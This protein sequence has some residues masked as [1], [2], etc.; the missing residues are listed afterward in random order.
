MTTVPRRVIDRPTARLAAGLLVLLTLIGLISAA[1]AAAD[2]GPS[3]AVTWGVAPI[4]TG[5]AHF[6]GAAGPGDTVRDAISIVNRSTTP[7]TLRVYASDAFTTATGGLDL[8]PAAQKPVDLGSW[9]TLDQDS[10]TLTSQ[11]TVVVPF[12]VRVP[13]DATPGDHT[14]GIVT[15]LVT[16][17]SG[18]AVQLDRRLGARYYL[19]VNGSLAPALAVSNVHVSYAASLNP[20][21]SGSATVTY[22]VANTGNVRLT[23]RQSVRVSGPFGVLAHSRAIADLPELL[24]GNSLTRSVVVHGVWPATH[25][26]AKVTLRPSATGVSAATSSARASTWGWPIGQL[27]ILVVVLLLAGGYWWLRRRRAR[28]VEA[29]IADAVSRALAGTQSGAQAT[30]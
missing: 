21:S 5:R 6:D 13:D 22:T 9:I 23:A 26:T 25:L 30:G 1:P 7:I 16:A 28:A 10:V 24:P 11:Q 29:A 19:R 8:L 12:T 3:D 2:P 17:N 15:S 14:A 4:G 18:A 27:V 20:A